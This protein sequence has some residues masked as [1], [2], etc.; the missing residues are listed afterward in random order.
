[1]PNMENRRGRTPLSE[2]ARSELARLVREKGEGAVAEL[3]G[4][5]P[6][7]IAR[8]AAGFD[9]NGTTAAY[10]ESRL[11]PGTSGTSGHKPDAQKL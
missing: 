5:H 10:F 3:L 4:A 7:T 8:G 6:Q 1:M 11:A 9:L 2:A